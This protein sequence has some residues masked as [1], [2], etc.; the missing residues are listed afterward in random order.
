MHPWLVLRFFALSKLIKMLM[1]NLKNST[2]G[3][4]H[5][6]RSNRH[7]KSM[8]FPESRIQILSNCKRY[9]DGV[10]WFENDELQHMVHCRLQSADVDLTR[11]TG[12]FEFLFDFRSGS[13][14]KFHLCLNTILRDCPNLNFLYYLLFKFQLFK[15]E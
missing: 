11:Q 9:A 1:N 12:T 14:L 10:L 8:P 6:S 15:I 4:S 13:I 5:N 2:F 7:S 3:R